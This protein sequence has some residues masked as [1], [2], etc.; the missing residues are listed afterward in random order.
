MLQCKTGRP[1][2]EFVHVSVMNCPAPGPIEPNGLGS[3]ALEGHLKPTFSSTLTT[4]SILGIHIPNA[5]QMQTE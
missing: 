5:S 1:F 3:V 4:L 2:W